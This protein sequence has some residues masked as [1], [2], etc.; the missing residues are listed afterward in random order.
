MLAFWGCSG[1]TGI[2]IPSS[3]TS[4][5]SS[6]FYGCSGLTSLSFPSGITSIGSSAFLGCSGLTSIYV[7]AEKMPKLGTNMFDDCD[8][9][10]VLFTFQKELMTIIGFLNLVILRT[11]SSLTQQASIM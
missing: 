8:A 6:A 4:I 10:N 9:K 2:T 7:Y 3:V 5:G 11:S 1:L